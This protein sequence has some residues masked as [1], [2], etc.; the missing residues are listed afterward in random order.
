MEILEVKGYYFPPG[1]TEQVSGFE[2][3]VY[4]RDNTIV[5]L[6]TPRVT[7]AVVEELA[8]YLKKS[9]QEYLVHL[10]LETIIEVL[11]RASRLWLKKDYPFRELALK[12]IPVITGF[13]R[14]VVAESIDIEMESSLEADIWRAL[15]SEINNPL[16]L[17]DFQYDPELSGFRRAFGPELMVSFFSENIPALPHLLFMRSALV[18]AACLGKVASGEP[19]FA[20]LYLKTIEDIDPA[21]RRKGSRRCR[22]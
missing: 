22:L 16:Y 6:E 14:E 4:Q 8:D 15:R 12:T 7:R 9:R 13:S 10:K 21:W 11:D 20:P 2:T 18:K 5:Q 19:T 3:D 1:F 17:D